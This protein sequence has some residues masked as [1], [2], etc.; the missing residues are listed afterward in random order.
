VAKP[1]RTRAM[2]TAWTEAAWHDYLHWSQAD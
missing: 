2:K 1:R